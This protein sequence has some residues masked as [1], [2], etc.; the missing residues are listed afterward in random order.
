MTSQTITSDKRTEFALHQPTHKALIKEA[1][2]K[3]QSGSFGN[4]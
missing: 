3:T 2:M 4:I 1:L